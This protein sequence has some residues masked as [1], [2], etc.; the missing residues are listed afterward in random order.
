MSK[1]YDV[2]YRR[3]RTLQMCVAE[4]DRPREKAKKY[5]FR[6]LSTSELLALLIGSGSTGENVVELCQRIIN[7]QNGKLHN[8][9]RMN[10]NDLVRRYRGIGEVKAIEILA[11]LELARRYQQEEF[12]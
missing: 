9:A 5:G 1:E 4:D 2:E 12:D 11:A 8:I 10:I 7:E 6:S 3:S